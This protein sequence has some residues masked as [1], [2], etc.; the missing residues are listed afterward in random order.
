MYGIVYYCLVY[1]F[2]F[3]RVCAFHLCAFRL[4]VCWLQWMAPEVLASE[5]YAE[6][7]DVYSF[8]IVCWELLTRACPYQG[9]SQIQVRLRDMICFHFF[10]FFFL[11]FSC[12]SDGGYHMP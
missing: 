5:K 10:F 8:A 3:V 12:Q 7:A 1:W 11:C 4:Y 9:L 2:T 6:T